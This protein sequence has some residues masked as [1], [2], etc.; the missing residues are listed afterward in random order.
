MVTA[1]ENG[2]SLASTGL[3]RSGRYSDWEG[4]NPRKFFA[5]SKRRHVYRLAIAYGVVARLLIQIATQVFPFFEIPKWNYKVVTVVRLCWGVA[6]VLLVFFSA[7]NYFT[8]IGLL[9]NT[10]DSL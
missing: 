4:M 5:E 7:M 2:R 1:N 6:G 10:S 3:E 8:H 9:M